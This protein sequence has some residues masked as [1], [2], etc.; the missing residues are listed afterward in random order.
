MSTESAICEWLAGQRE[1]MTSLLREMVDIDSGS[2]NKPGIDA[3]GPVG[4]KAHSPDA[5]LM[6]DSL[7]PRAQACARAIFGLDRAG[8]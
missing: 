4:G 8:L 5:F 7:V 1:T 2:Y 6:L 3:V